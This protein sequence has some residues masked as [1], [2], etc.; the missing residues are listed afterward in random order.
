MVLNRIRRAVLSAWGIALACE[1]A[2]CA[3][4]SDS[5]RRPYHGPMEASLELENPL[6]ACRKNE[7]ATSGRDPAGRG[8]SL[9]SRVVTLHELAHRVP[10]RAANEYRRALKAKY[11]GDTEAAIP[12]FQKAIS[13]DP[14]FLAALNDLGTIY[15]QSGNLNLAIDHFRRAI[16]VDPHAAM[17]CSNLAIAYLRQRQ[18][19]DAERV[20]RRAVD[21]DRSGPEGPLVLGASLVLEGR[22]TAEAERMLTKASAELTLGKFWL[23]VGLIQRGALS[24]A[25]DQLKAYLSEAHESSEGIAS[26]LLKRLESIG[27]GQQLDI[28]SFDYMSN[29]W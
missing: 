9:I 21:L 8:H 3:Q 27:G 4:T 28:P 13:I 26:R 22:F 1:G 11:K 20:A 2:V 7:Y 12:H 10:D 5:I 16:A 29:Y 25:K 23:A 24:T 17:P 6:H 19:G 15:L 14:E 18:Y